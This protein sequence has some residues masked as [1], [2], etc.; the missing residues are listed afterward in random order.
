MGEK[1]GIGVRV[2]VTMHST[3]STSKNFLNLVSWFIITMG[4]C[5]TVKALESGP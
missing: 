2:S 5:S 4:F 3:H 1:G